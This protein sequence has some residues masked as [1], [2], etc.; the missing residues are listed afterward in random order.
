MIMKSLS[1]RFVMLSMMDVE[2]H[3]RNS[4]WKDTSDLIN[5]DKPMIIQVGDYGYEVQSCGGDGDI[6]GFVIQCKEEPV[7]KWEGAPPQREWQGLTDEEVGMLTVFNGLHHVEV[8]LLAK[9]TRAI[10]A[11]LKEKNT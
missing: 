10:E 7:C 4:K 3:W 11:K 2:D 5:P 1:M 8:P 6:E 9:F